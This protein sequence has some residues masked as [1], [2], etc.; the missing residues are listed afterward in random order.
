MPITKQVDLKLSTDSIKKR[1]GQKFSGFNRKSMNRQ[2]QRERERV[3]AWMK[4]FNC[5]LAFS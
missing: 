2:S 1:F 3:K 4:S 5:L